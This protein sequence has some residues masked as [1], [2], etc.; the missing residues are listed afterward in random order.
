MF[1]VCHFSDTHS[2]VRQLTADIIQKPFA[3]LVISVF[4][5][6][7]DQHESDIYLFWGRRTSVRVCDCVCVCVCVY[8]NFVLVLGT[9]LSWWT[10]AFCLRRATLN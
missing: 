1:F 3:C 8:I 9:W 6:S 4:F 7:Y 5:Q 10:Q 2:F